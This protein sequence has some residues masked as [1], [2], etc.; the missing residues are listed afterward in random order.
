MPSVAF[1]E[2][3]LAWDRIAEAAYYVAFVATVALGMARSPA[4]RPAMACLG[5]CAVW[6]G[7]NTARNYRGFSERY[8]GR[9]RWLKKVS[10]IQRRIYSRII[11][12]R[13]YDRTF[14]VLDPLHDPDWWLQRPGIRKGFGWVFVFIGA[15]FFL[16]AVFDPGDALRFPEG[17]IQLSAR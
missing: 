7:L 4:F 12:R 8:F 3:R 10:V 5:L 1:M 13:V 14:G 16:V 17:A 11:G 15:T 2:N 6:V 9:F